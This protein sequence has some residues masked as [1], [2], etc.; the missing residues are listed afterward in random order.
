MT[1]RAYNFCAGPCTLPLEV[2]EETQREFV[3]YRGTGMAMIEMSHRSKQY[4]AVH[5]SARALAREVFGAP[6]EFDVLFI[7]GGASLQF[8]MVPMNFLKPGQ[9]GAYVNSG[10]WAQGAIADAIH[11]GD[12]YTAWD[13]ADDNYTRMPAAGEITLQPDTRY[14]HVTSNETIGGIRINEWP[15]VKVPLGSDSIWGENNRHIQTDRGMR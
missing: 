3:N 12:V 4:D 8:A 14:L 9:R 13:G 2:L 1:R 7:Q 10:S 11:H 15:D 6:E 5:Q